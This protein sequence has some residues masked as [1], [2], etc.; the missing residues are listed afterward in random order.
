MLGSE[1]RGDVSQETLPLTSM[2]QIS[3]DAKSI[4]LGY[5]VLAEDTFWCEQGIMR[6]PQ[7]RDSEDEQLLADFILS[8]TLNSPFAASKENFDSYYGKG[9]KDRSDEINVAISKYGEENLK[10]DV[11]AVLSAIKTTIAAVIKDK[12]EKNFLKKILNPS[13]GSNPVKEPFYSVF[14]AF[15]ELIIKESKDPFE[16]SGIIS[17]VQ[18]LASKIKT[19]ST[20]IPHN[21]V[22][23]INLTKGL[24]QNYFKPSSTPHRSSGSYAIDLENY[25]RRSR[26]EAPRYDFKQGFYTLSNNRQFDD[27][28]FESFL[29]NIAAMANFGKSKKGYLFVG[30]SDKESDTQRVETLDMMQVPRISP[31][32]IVGLEREAKLR[33][34]SLDDYILFITRIP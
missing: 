25:L 14:M 5:G 33:G 11:K 27:N 28:F 4:S 7:L 22:H 1:I 9:E 26:I 31:F 6:I 3:I 30:I 10:S 2:P 20:V 16:Y 19:S 15:Y 18:N 21:R 29:Q 17:S 13:A 8:I 23:N 32:G 24:I 34:S 12:N